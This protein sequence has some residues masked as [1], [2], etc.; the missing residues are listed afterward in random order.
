MV[1]Y[2]YNLDLIFHSLADPTRRAV[3]AQIGTGEKR[4]TDLETP[5][6]MS[7]AA[8]SKHIKVL[9]TAGL[10]HRRKQGRES[11]LRI[12]REALM[13]ADEWI[14]T[15]TRLWNEQLD[16]LEKYLSEKRQEADGEKTNQQS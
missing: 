16:S 4:I 15:Y 10:V 12:N 5:V 8:V 6:K 2:E 13:N 11:F 7:L 14:S 3:L 1:N 9:E